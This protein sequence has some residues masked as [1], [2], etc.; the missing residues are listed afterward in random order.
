MSTDTPRRLTS[1]F[2]LGPWSEHQ[3]RDVAEARMM[4]AAH[5]QQFGCGGRHHGRGTPDCPREL[6]HHHDEFCDRPAG[7]TTEDND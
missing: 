4:R 1:F 6:H 2:G 5:G 3:I 7:L